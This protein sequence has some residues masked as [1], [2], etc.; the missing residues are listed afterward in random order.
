MRQGV[1]KK[2]T[3]SSDSLTTLCWINFSIFEEK[4][5]SLTLYL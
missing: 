2:S 5:I 1:V 3:D 4:R